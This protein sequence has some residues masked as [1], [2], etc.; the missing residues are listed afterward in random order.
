MIP[1]DGKVDVRSPQL[2]LI[3]LLP[4]N[5]KVPRGLLLVVLKSYF[6]GGNQADSTQYDVVTLAAVS[7][8]KDEWIPFE[9]DWRKNLRKHKAEHLHTTDAATL[10]Y[11]FKG[12]TEKQRDAF[13]LDCVRVAEH[14]SVRQNREGRP[15]RFGL[16]PYTITVVLKDFVEAHRAMPDTTPNTAEEACATHALAACLQWGAYASTNRFQLFFDQGERYRGHICDRIHNPKAIK[17][18]PMLSSIVANT[19]ADM[20]LVPALQLADLFA[21]CVSQQRRESPFK[22]QTRLLKIDRRDERLDSI[23]LRKTVPGAPEIIRSWKL[24][25]R[26]PTR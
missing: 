7:G 6:D 10:N 21:W 2:S 9:R 14:H 16:Y 17:R 18:L 13:L 22:W 25:K 24:P 26:K 8:T 19:E 20:R 11:N 5:G 23:T 1:R 3:D 4:T 12:W 15:G